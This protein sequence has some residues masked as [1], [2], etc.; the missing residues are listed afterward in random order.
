[1]TQVDRAIRYDKL[2]KSFD[3]MSVTLKVLERR[4]HVRWFFF[5]NS[6]RAVLIVRKDHKLDCMRVYLRN[7]AQRG[8]EQVK[9]ELKDEMR[10]TL[11]SMSSA[12]STVTE[13]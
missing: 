10:R 1:M 4:Y 7:E 13:A 2:K 9:E 6:S 5:Q 12:S 3:E 11:L 8:L